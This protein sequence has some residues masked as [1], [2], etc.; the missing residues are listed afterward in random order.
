MTSVPMEI[1]L[2]KR[3]RPLTWSTRRLRTGA[4][5]DRGP[6]TSMIRW[7][8]ECETPNNSPICRIVRLVRQ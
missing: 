3:S 4:N 1:G 6:R 5:A 7:A 2:E 8:A